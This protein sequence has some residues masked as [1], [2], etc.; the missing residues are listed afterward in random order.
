MPATYTGVWQPGA[1][2]HFVLCDW[3]EETFTDKVQELVGEGFHL[4]S[5][6][7]TLKSGIRKWHGVATKTDRSDAQAKLELIIPEADF[8]R[9][10][11]EMRERGFGFACIDSQF[12]SGKPAYSVFWTRDPQ[13]S[14]FTR[15]VTR[16]K[17]LN[18]LGKA[19]GAQL[20]P[21]DI[22][23]M[24]DGSGRLWTAVYSPLKEDF[25]FFID[26]DLQSLIKQSEV[27]ARRSSADSQLADLS[28]ARLIAYRGP[29]DRIKY[30]G[31]FRERRSISF[32]GSKFDKSELIAAKKDM[33]AQAHLVD[34]DALGAFS[35]PV[36][37]TGD[38]SDDIRLHIRYLFN[39][40]SAAEDKINLQIKN[41]KTVFARH[42]LDVAVVSSK[43]TPLSRIRAIRLPQGG[44]RSRRFSE[45]QRF[46]HD[47]RHSSLNSNDIAVYVV[48]KFAMNLAGCAAH[49]NRKEPGLIVAIKR[50]TQW[51]LAHELG[52]VLSLFHKERRSRKRS[53][54]ELMSVPTSEINTSRPKLSN[55]DLDDIRAKLRELQP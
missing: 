35:Q 48:P 16:A 13:N 54:S 50:S 5:L 10:R 52:H 27:L 32:I 25:L 55:R 4:T 17:F 37:T 31:L 11:D 38:G 49:P 44:C 12:E 30:A 42:G 41:T 36:T 3:K 43:K 28:L 26:T 33:Q 34:I 51:T 46:I 8:A 40:S 1:K 15:G 22:S 45:D 19:P 20:V 14:K 29:D 9:R 2:K 7:S 47:L 6:C 39:P 18:S 24:N 53:K 23:T 21:H